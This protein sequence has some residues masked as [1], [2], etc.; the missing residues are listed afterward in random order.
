MSGSRRAIVPTPARTIGVYA[1]LLVGAVVW[2]APIVVMV[3]ASL[4]PDER[5]LS[6][7][8]TLAGLDPLDGSLQNYR[9]VFVRVPFGRIFFNTVFI[10]GSIVVAGLVVNSLAAYALARLRWPGRRLVLALVLALL[11]VPFEAVALPLFYGT[12]VLGW[13]DTYL[14]QILPFVATSMSIYLF[15]TF[16]L[17]FPREVEEA[18]TVDGAGPW[19]IF[20]E[21]VV[22]Q[23]GPVFAT[24]AIVTFLLQWGMYLW[25]LLVTTRVDVRPLP[26]GIATFRTLPPVQWGDIM[27][28]A[29][30]MVAPVAVAFVVLQ[31]WF[32]RSVAASG[33]KG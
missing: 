25:P 18:A 33:V 20:L 31:R 7:I 16:F 17:D 22:P 2:V 4:K 19:R 8:G 3:T 32:V 6:E 9:D 28:F 14:V 29:V 11:V 10:N 5:V 12:A 21:I 23:S 27:A 15:Y 1:I 13:R 26:L 24:V 30:L